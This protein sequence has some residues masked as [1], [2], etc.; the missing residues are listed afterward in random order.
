MVE[1]FR[2][3]L[4]VFMR[5]AGYAYD[6]QKGAETSFVRRLSRMEYPKFHMYTRVAE[7]KLFL[8]LHLDQ[9]RPSYEGASV[10]SGD[11]DS[12]LVEQELERVARLLE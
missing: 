3:N 7:G 4:Q 12:S 8:S 11:Y 10:H 2:E 9:K 6:R 5:R 1:G